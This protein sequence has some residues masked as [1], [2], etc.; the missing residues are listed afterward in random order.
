[1]ILR[2]THLL[3]ERTWWSM[4]ELM[5]GLMEELMQ[6]AEEKIHAKILRRKARFLIVLAI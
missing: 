6:R 5:E 4:E 3:E 2:Y 1:M